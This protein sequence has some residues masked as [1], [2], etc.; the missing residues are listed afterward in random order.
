MSQRRAV[1]QRGVRFQDLMVLVRIHHSNEVW[2]F[3]HET[4]MPLHSPRHMDAAI[5]RS[6]LLTY[7]R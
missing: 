4:R 7:P 1:P 5:G 3:A 2:L 6:I